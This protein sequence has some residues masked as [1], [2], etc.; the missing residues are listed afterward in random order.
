MWRG[1]SNLLYAAAAAAVSIGAIVWSGRGAAPAPQA[2]AT[3]DLPAAV[4]AGASPTA[5]PDTSR[6]S[7]PP[8]VADHEAER[9]AALV[10]ENEALH[11]AQKRLEMENEA[12][13]NQLQ[14]L[15]RWIL[16]NFQ[17]RYPIPEHLVGR[18]DMPAVTDEFR[19]HD[20]LAAL[21]RLTPAERERLDDAFR[22][23]RAMADEAEARVLQATMPT[24]SEL[25]VEIPP[26][27]AAGEEVRRHLMAALETA[28]GTNRAPWAAAAAGRDLDRRF[29]G[30]GRDHRTVRFEL[31][32]R[33]D[34]E[35]PWIRVRDERVRVDEEGRRRRESVEMEAA[36][37]PA[38]YESLVNRLPL[39]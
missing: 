23:A 9:R 2:A 29:G 10:A 28:L 24:A 21:L 22:V 18:L 11:A 33:E 5:F 35:A 20:D 12:L 7:A 8:R 34:A 38:E 3:R 32:Y 25:V 26:H 30:F 13:R 15:L 36:R 16:D 19:V 1:V 17:G 39:E 4:P 37:L 6:P 14:A 27:E 31:V